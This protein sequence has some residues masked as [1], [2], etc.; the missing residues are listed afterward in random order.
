MRK[1]VAD[2]EPIEP[3]AQDK[4]ALVSSFTQELTKVG[5]NVIRANTKNF[6]AKIIDLLQAREIDQI[7]LEPNLL[8]EALLQKAGMTISH[9]PAPTL[10][11]GVTPHISFQFSET[12]G[13]TK[14]IC[15]LADTGSILIAD[16]EGNPLQA[17]L[18]PQIHIALLCTSAI[19]PSLA[20]AMPLPILHQSKVA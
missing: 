14:A 9:T 20:D 12:C 6:T 15:G 1:Q 4:E 10:P 17:S 16:G 5:G 18:L 3:V 7:Q 19:L 13:V 8:D 11:V 2:E